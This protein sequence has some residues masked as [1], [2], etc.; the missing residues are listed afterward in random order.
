MQRISRLVLLSLLAASILL[1]AC[2]AQAGGSS[3]AVQA[4]QTYLQAL[5][6]KDAT[7]L[8]NQSCKAWESE[9]TL[10]MDSFQAVT[11]TLEGV[12]CQETG[13]DGSATLV[14]CKG[15]IVATYNGEKQNLDLSPRTYKVVQEGGEWRVCGY[16]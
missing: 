11:A 5:V 10:E 13:K 7:K 1:S 12:S 4:V 9:A 14:N 2:G 16:H 8:D 15:N 3:P 6:A